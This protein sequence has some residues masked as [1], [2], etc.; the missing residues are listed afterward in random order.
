VL[1]IGNRKREM[2][3]KMEGEVLNLEHVE[4][5]LESQKAAAAT[6]QSAKPTSESAKP[7]PTAGQLAKPTLESAKPTL[8]AS[9]ALHVPESAKPTHESAKPPP[10]AVAALEAPESAKLTFESAEPTRTVPAASK[11][12]SDDFASTIAALVGMEVPEVPDEEMVDYE[13]TPERAE[14]NVV[15]LSTDYYIIEDDSVVAE[16]N[17]ATESAIFQKPH[18]SINYLKPLHVKAM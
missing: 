5:S 16:F 7:T 9:A 17:F 14:V 3:A 15:Y 8:L 4:I 18:D 12:S 2:L 1:G 13:A 10:T 6:G 11:V